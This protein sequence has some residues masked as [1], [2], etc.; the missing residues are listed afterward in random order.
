[1]RRLSGPPPTRCQLAAAAG[2]QTRMTPAKAKKDA[3]NIAIRA[4]VVR[5]SSSTVTCLR[6]SL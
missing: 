6:G 3:L 1:M 5:G 2:V 4:Q